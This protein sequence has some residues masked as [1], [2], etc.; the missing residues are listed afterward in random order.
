MF[1]SFG[2]PRFWPA[3]SQTS[4][5]NQKS[6]T[7]AEGSKNEPKPKGG[8]FGPSRNLRPLC[9]SF[10][11]QAIPRDRKTKLLQR[12]LKFRLGPKGPP[13]GFGSFFD[14]S[15]A[16]SLFWLSGLVWLAAGQNLGTP[17]P[18]NF[19]FSVFHKVFSVFYQFLS[20][21]SVFHKVL[22]TFGRFA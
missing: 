6:E 5:E 17:K 4:P 15:A 14:P 19:C 20:V 11:F 7:A 16:V 9:S 8:P 10:V 2:V 18:S 3:A 21:L 12:G 22:D 1:W 13:F